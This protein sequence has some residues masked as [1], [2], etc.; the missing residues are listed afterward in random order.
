MKIYDVINY[1]NDVSEMMLRNGAENF[2][3][4]GAI[5]NHFKKGDGFVNL[6]KNNLTPG[7][8]RYSVLYRFNDTFG[9]FILEVTD[10]SYKA[11][12][13]IDYNTGEEIEYYPEMEL[14]EFKRIIKRVENLICYKI[15]INEF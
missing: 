6:E 10:T 5:I 14:K 1:F 11:Y 2:N 4:E 12:G 9:V 3:P 13:T 15:D 7:I 8:T